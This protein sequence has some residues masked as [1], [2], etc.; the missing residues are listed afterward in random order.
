[1]EF[2]QTEKRENYIV[3]TLDRG[4]ANPINEAMILELRTLVKELSINDEVKGVILTGKE[5]FFSAGLD[6]IE[7]YEFDT[8]QL[9]SF[10]INFTSLIRELSA[11]SKPIIAAIT[12]HSPAGGCVLA[13]CCDYRVMADGNYKIG[14]N[15]I[16]VGITLPEIIFNIY[17]FWIGRRRAYQNLMEGKM[18]SPEEALK[19]GLIDEICPYEVIMNRA[20]TKLKTYL[21]FDSATWQHSKINL[22]KG[23]LESLNKD[24]DTAYQYTLKDWWSDETRLRMGEIVKTLRK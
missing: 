18:M 23:L 4:K 12:G 8:P 3:V 19:I 6:V 10:W 16:P 11:F 9:K 14:L 21:S 22:K 1:M 17:S 7:L 15:E 2:L 20:T 24:F 5:N 13:I